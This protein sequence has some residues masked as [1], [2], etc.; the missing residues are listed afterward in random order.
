MRRDRI[1]RK[2]SK[3]PQPKG[4]FPRRSLNVFEKWTQRDNIENVNILYLGGLCPQNKTS[5]DGFIIC[6][7][8]GEDVDI[9]NVI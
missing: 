8:I 4:S 9:T 1:S 3:A 6:L 5:N 2:L 7:I